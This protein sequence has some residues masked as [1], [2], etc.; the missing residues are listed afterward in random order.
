MP[1]L[2][3]L[4]SCTTI[5]LM[6]K[7][8]LIKIK[9][10][11]SID[12][13]LIRKEVLWPHINNGN[14]SLNIDNNK[15]T[16]HLGT[17]VNNNLVSIGTFLPELNSHFS[18]NNQYRL[19]A[20]A[21]KKEYTGKGYGRKLFLHA[22]NILIRNKVELLW[23]DARI[24]AIPFYKKLDMKSLNKTYEIKNIGPHQTMY[25]KLLS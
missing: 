6:K 13:H 12:T 8:N 3:E 4:Y 1:S 7:N 25:I 15:A 17:F 5:L 11:S 19:R 9:Y 16:F 22:I 24:E 21:T 23:C 14:Y 2:Q 18:K 20:M 10:I